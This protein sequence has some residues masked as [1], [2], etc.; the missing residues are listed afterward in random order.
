MRYHIYTDGSASKEEIGSAF[1]I[2]TENCFIT[3]G[4]KKFNGNKPSYAETIAV[5]CAVEALLKL[6]RLKPTDSI[7]IHVDCWS[8]IDF[9]KTC[10]KS[11]VCN[12]SDD[13]IKICFKIVQ[14]ASK[15]YEVVFKK[16]T[17]HTAYLNAN[18]LV[19]KLAKQVIRSQGN[20]MCS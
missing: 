19:D 5:G 17:A 4:C 11:G 20:L 14:E 8:A 6:N 15:R 18:T 10:L 3:Q 1:L 7:Y 16:A 2:L 9:Y 12:S 13:K